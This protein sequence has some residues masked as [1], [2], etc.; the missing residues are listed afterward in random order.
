MRAAAEKAIR[1]DPL[2]AEAHA[3]LGMALRTRCA[4]GGVGKELPARDR[5]RSGAARLAHWSF[6]C[7]SSLASRPDRRGTPSVAHRGGEPTRSQPQIQFTWAG[8]SFRLAAMMRPQYTAR[9][10]SRTTRTRICVWSRP[11]RPGEEP[12][13]QSG[14]SLKA[15]PERIGPIWATLMRGRAAARRLKSWQLIFHR[16]RYYRP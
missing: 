6:R 14:F 15:R 10:S 4:M 8:C 13:R 5:A 11:V 7:I 3:A 1:L 9:S 16:D 12:R 2:L